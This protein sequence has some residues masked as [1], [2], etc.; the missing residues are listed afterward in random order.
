[1]FGSSNP[2]PSRSEA[3]GSG[4]V[5]GGGLIDMAL[6]RPSRRARVI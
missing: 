6:A 3:D 5:L 4:D 1:M 2:E